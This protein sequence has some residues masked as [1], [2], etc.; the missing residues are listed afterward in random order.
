MTG[1][2]K[3]T[4]GENEFAESTQPVKVQW[5]TLKLEQVQFNEP[6]EFE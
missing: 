3:N 6:H 1:K 5:S 2:V 4:T